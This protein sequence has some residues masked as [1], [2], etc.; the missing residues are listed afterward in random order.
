L[1]AICQHGGLDEG[2][3]QQVLPLRVAIEQREGARAQAIAREHVEVAK[4]NLYYALELA[5]R[6][7][8]AIRL[9]SSPHRNL[10]K[11]GAT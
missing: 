10:A 1:Q 11:R 6:V 7:M 3:A 4:L 2:C 5:E 9:V 8:P